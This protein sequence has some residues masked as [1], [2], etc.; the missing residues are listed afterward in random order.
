MLQDLDGG[1]GLAHGCELVEFFSCPDE[2]QALT[3][4]LVA[5]GEGG[6]A[7]PLAIAHNG[8]EAAV[9]RMRDTGWIHLRAAQLPTRKRDRLGI[10]DT[11]H[12][13]ASH[14]SRQDLVLLRVDDLAARVHGYTGG[15]AAQLEHDHAIVE[16]HS[17]GGLGALCA[18]GPGAFEAVVERLLKLESCAVPELDGAIFGAGDDE[19]EF[20]VE[21]GDYFTELAVGWHM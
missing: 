17:A 21:C 1:C 18:D 14:C 19:G 10:L 3:E 5:Q 20:G 8:H 7:D 4:G 9:R 12:V 6:I 2:I 11:C 13:L 15:L 16:T